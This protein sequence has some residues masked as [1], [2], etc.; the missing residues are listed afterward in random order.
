VDQV[1]AKWT[2]RDVAVG[3]RGH[4][5]HVANVSQRVTYNDLHVATWPLKT[6]RRMATCPNVSDVALGHV[7]TCNTVRVGTRLH[8]VMWF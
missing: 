1:V 3:Q 4:Y 8:V 5:C 6:R 2:I 7:A